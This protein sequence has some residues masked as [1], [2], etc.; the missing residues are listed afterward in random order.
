M[1]CQMMHG[2][3]GSQSEDEN[4]IYSIII[5]MK[6]TLAVNDIRKSKIIIKSIDKSMLFSLSKAYHEFVGFIMAL[7]NA[8]KGKPMQCDYVRSEV[9]KFRTKGC[10]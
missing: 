3:I 1:Y 10:I 7:N 8:V 4:F 9:L 2:N 5:N 6:R